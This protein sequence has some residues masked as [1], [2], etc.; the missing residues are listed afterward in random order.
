VR[1]GCASQGR[2]GRQGLRSFSVSG[3]VREPG[4]KLAP[5]GITLRELVDEFCGGMLPGHT[6]KAYLPGGA[7]GGILPARLADL[8]LDFDTLQPH[9]CFI[10]SAAVIVLS[11][12][13]A[14][15]STRAQPDALLRARELRPVHA[16]PQRHRQGAALIAADRWDL[17]LLADLSQVMRD[18]SICGLGQ[19]APNPVDS[20]MRH[21][22]RR[23][24]TVNA[25]LHFTLD[26]R[27]VA[28]RARRD[29]PRGGAARRHRHPAPVPQARPDA[30]RQLP[31][32][33]GRGGRRAHAGGVVLP[34][35]AAGMVVQTASERALKSQRLVLELLQADL[36]AT[37]LTRTTRSTHWA[38]GWAWAAALPGRAGG[39]GRRLAP[40]DRVNL[41]A[42]IQCTRCLRACRDEQANDVIGLAAR[43]AAGEDR[44]RHGRRDGRVHLRGLRR[45]RAGLPDRRAGA[46]ARRGAGAPDRSVDSSAR[47][48]ASAASSPTTSRTTASCASTAATARPTR[49]GCA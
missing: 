20:V 7:S 24:G 42:C 45:M 8:P 4:V 26:G 46:G 44:V 41:D 37:A 1:T 23:T 6:L 19:A 35:G 13:D 16:L 31:R 18:A 3:R 49:A 2:H 9:G 21:F 22:P 36:P 25:P 14:R 38:R 43:G 48:A 17:P 47:T 30:G 34:R 11:Q 12:H 32:L 10:G 27:A 33:R 5:A 39:G 29:D 28:G 40:G 15:C